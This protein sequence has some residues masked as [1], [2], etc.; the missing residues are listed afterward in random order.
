MLLE[1]RRI[2]SCLI[3]AFSRMYF[4]SHADLGQ[5]R[6]AGGSLLYAGFAGSGTA[7]ANAPF[8]PSP[9]GPSYATSRG[10]HNADWSKEFVVGFNDIP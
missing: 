3:I 7:S 9:C 4:M 5:R 2:R 1:M 8:R 10:G 6:L